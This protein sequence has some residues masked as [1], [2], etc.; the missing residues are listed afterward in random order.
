[1]RN[2]ERFSKPDD[3]VSPNFARKVKILASLIPSEGTMLD[4]GCWDGRMAKEYARDFKGRKVGA[5]FNLLDQAKQVFDELVKVD[6]DRPPLPFPDR[7]FDC[8]MLGEVIEHLYDTDTLIQEIHRILKPGGVLVLTTPNL[9]SLLNRLL[10]LFGFQPVETEVSTQSVRF[11]NPMN[12]D[13]TPAGHIRN[14]TCRALL[15]F[16]K[17]H[18]FEIQ[19]VTSVPGTKRQPIM[20]LERLAGTLSPCFGGDLI[21]K[22]IRGN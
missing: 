4:I 13:K 18:H 9:A 14:F 19:T 6:L 20:A 11:G 8:I 22:A 21:V 17:S 7:S 15:D 2:P 1:M 5:D 12:P 3:A 10:L 16:L